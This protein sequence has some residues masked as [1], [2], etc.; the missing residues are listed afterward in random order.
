MLGAFVSITSLV[1]LL[2]SH[3]CFIYFTL[4]FYFVTGADVPVL[5]SQN[6][7]QQNKTQARRSPGTNLG[8]SENSNA[9]PTNQCKTATWVL[10]GILCLYWKPYLVFSLRLVKTA[11]EDTY[12]E[13][14]PFI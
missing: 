6:Y 8:S 11:S 14:V 9:K 5:F 3:R 7:Q 1:F 4:P 10:H 13:T 12:N 2:N